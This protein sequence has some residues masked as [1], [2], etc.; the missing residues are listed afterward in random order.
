MAIQ[1]GGS[2]KT[3][4]VSNLGAA[5]A[6]KGKR[7]LLID[8]DQQGNLTQDD[9]GVPDEQW[10]KGNSLAAAFQYGG[11]LTV[12]KNVRPNLDLVMGGPRI[13][14]VSTAVAAAAEDPPDMAENL[15]GAL[16]KLQAEGQ[17]D[18][19]VIDSGHGDKVLMIALLE[20][21]TDLIIPT[22]EDSASL[23]GIA[24]LAA[25]MKRAIHRGSKVQLLGVVM[26]GVDP[27][28]TTRYEYVIEQV[29]EILQGTDVEPFDA[30]I[31]HARPVSVAQRAYS[32]TAQEIALV[33]SGQATGDLQS[34]RLG[35][36]RL[37]A[38]MAV[39]LANDYQKLT[40]EVLQR[41]ARNRAQQP[42]S[43]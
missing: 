23:R 32:R 35:K 26:V 24:Q 43:Q 17:Y 25:S 8:A 6:A 30:T 5:I 3:S 33:A 37:S 39:N 41:L 28:A 31:R 34:L 21:S 20:V 12:I 1:K 2:F 15:R 18:L 13:G 38:D 9:L 42:V 16:V 22:Q 14:M 10:D 7:V 4:V 36:G 11:E 29:R 27:K 40:R 19:I